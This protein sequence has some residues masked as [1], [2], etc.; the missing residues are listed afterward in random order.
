MHISSLVPSPELVST[1]PGPVL[2]QWHSR[3]SGSPGLM[4]C[5]YLSRRR[6]LRR[7]RGV[8]RQAAVAHMPKPPASLL[9]GARPERAQAP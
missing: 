3:F 1:A 6:G 2:F 8:E 7:G 5:A 9:K 4:T